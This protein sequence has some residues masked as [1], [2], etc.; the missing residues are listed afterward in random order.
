MCLTR[1]Q[2]HR[3]ALEGTDTLC[4]QA[5]C[6]AEHWDTIR[7]R[8]WAKILGLATWYIL[9]I[10]SQLIWIFICYYLSYLFHLAAQHIVS[11]NCS[12]YDAAQKLLK[13]LT[14]SEIFP[15]LFINKMFKN[16]QFKCYITW[17]S[18]Q[19]TRFWFAIFTVQQG[20]KTTVRMILS[21]WML[22]EIFKKKLIKNIPRKSSTR[23]HSKFR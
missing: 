21:P 22:H 23:V 13:M 15:I 6:L 8:L 5:N 12:Y 20:T 11:H 3:K 17:R 16:K 19:L 10:I 18:L 2:K 9:F 7:M 1:Q 4:L 14:Y